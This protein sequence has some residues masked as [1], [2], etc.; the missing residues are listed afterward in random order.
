MEQKIN[1]FN[2]LKKPINWAQKANDKIKLNNIKKEKNTRVAKSFKVYPGELIRNFD[3]R[4]NK[5]QVYFDDKDY[6]KNYV[7]S[8]K[9][10][11][12]LMALSEKFKLYELYQETNKIGQIDIN[13]ED[14]KNFI[15]EN[16]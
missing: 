4:I 11:M 9:Y 8:G 1:P 12:F 3:K 7:D 14:F 15:N 6:Q 10:I 5:L 16:L 2:E 13:N